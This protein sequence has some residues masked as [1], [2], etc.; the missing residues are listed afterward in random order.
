MPGFG[1]GMINDDFHIAGIRQVVAER[2]KRV[3]MYSMALGPR[4][5]KWKM[6]SLSGPKALLF[7]QLLIAF[8]TKSV[9]N[10]CTI[11]NSFLL[12]SLI[13]T[14]V[15]LEE[16]CLPSFEVLNCW[17][18]LVAS[19]LDDENEIPL[20]VIAS[21]SAS[22]FALPSIPLIVLHSLVTSV[23]WSMVSTKSLHFCRFCTQMRVWMAL[24]NLGISGEVGSLLRRS[25]SLFI[26]SSISAGTAS[27][28][29]LW[30]PVGMWCDAA[31]SRMVRKIFS[32]LWQSV[33]R[34][35]LLRPAST[36]CLYLSQLSF[37]G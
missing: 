7:L 21:F 11:S 16:V 6:P 15:S 33:G 12:V 24:F 29:S 5:F 8:I 1:I 35:H 13:T 14:L 22:R 2:L 25:S 36:S 17:L 10:V 34:E 32:S 9:V 31:L 30:H 20:K 19:C 23:F 26:T 27:S 3:V 28:W 37:L 18:N 4:C